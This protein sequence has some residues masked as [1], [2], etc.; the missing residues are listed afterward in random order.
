MNRYRIFISSTIDDLQAARVAVDEELTGAEVFDVVRVEKLPAAEEASRRVCLDEVASADAIVMI[1][2]DRYGFIPDR[3][4][5]DGLSVTHL[6]YR[7]SKRLNKPVFAFIR[8]DVEPEPSLVRFIQEVSNFDEGV[9]RKKW[10]SVDLL[11][12][13]VRRALLFWLARQA[14]A[15]QSQDDRQQA[16]EQLARYPETGELPVVID[17]S[18]ASD[19][20]VQQWLGSVLDNLSVECKRRL[21]PSPRLTAGPQ[22][23]STRPILEAQ[24]RAVP[25]RDRFVVTIA[26]RGDVAIEY[27]SRLELDVAYTLEGASF[28]AHAC[29]ALVFI[30]ADDWSSSMEQLFA[31][32]RSRSATHRTRSELAKT[33]AFISAV[34]NG[35]RSS[36]VARLLL[37]LPSL[38]PSTVSAGIM[39]LLAAQ[40][41][42]EHAGARHALAETEKLALRLL[43]SA[44]HQ[45]DTVPET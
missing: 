24:V 12:Q 11:R 7:E 20:A 27:P 13:E 31:A 22:L 33:A 17:T 23:D 30:V 25:R 2:N 35:Q 45:D 37:E 19:D 4:N 36:E 8:E 38:A 39:C 1:L 26:L 32:A 14:R 16:A 6:E 42:Q 41:R 43:M 29:L 28:L 15:R 9:L 3:S 5:S 10:R 21:L 18:A 34:N 40:L 44:L